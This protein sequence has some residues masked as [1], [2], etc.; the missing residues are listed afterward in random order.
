MPSQDEIDLLPDDEPLAVRWMRE[1]KAARIA[2]EQ[3]LAA[4]KGAGLAPKDAEEPFNEALYLIQRILERKLISK[5]FDP[6]FCLSVAKQIKEKGGASPKQTA[7]L[8]RVAEKFRVFA[9]DQNDN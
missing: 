8:R 9:P 7:A 3:E 6:S 2:A 5:R 4:G 1:A